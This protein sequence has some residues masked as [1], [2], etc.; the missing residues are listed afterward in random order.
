MAKFDVL[1]E[2]GREFERRMRLQTFPLAIKMLEKESDI[3]KGAQRP[4]KDLGYRLAA[5][6]GFAMSRREGISVAMTLEDMVCAEAV[7]G[8]GLAEPPQ[9]FFDGY[10]RFPRSVE[11]LEAGSVWAHEFPRFKVGKYM[12]IVTAPLTAV[13]FE[14]D[15]VVIYTDPAQLQMLLAAA[16]TKEGRELTCTVGAKAACVYSIVP[17]M[18]SGKYQVS[19][20]CGGDKRYAGAQHDEI[21]LSLPVGKIEDLLSSI[22]YMEEWGYRLP[23]RYVMKPNPE[24]PENYVEEGKMMGMYWL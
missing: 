6:Q 14:P 23:Y 22:R 10:H 16:A 13:N 3:P 15:V 9:S 18:T 11:S 19:L 2:Y 12:G 24:Q 20:P 8:Y 4:F 21:I 5:C 17:S 1:C 7:I